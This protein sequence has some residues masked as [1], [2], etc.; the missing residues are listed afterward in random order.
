[1][2]SS[3]DP[4]AI[5]Q[6]LAPT[7]ALAI[8]LGLAVGAAGALAWRADP[9]RG[10]RVFP[11]LAMFG[12]L[13][14][15]SAPLGHSLGHSLGPALGQLPVGRALGFVACAVAV[16]SAYLG[17]GLWVMWATRPRATPRPPAPVGA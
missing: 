6:A 8:G 7:C 16:A 9:R 3:T 12:L 17:A 5:A 14:I 11:G 2:P 4:S 1:M 10:A 13:L 15:P